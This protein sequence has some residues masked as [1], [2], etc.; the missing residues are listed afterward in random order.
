MPAVL[1]K[2]KRTTSGSSGALRVESAFF[3]SHPDAAG[4]FR[5]QAIA[6]GQFLVS[7]AATAADEDESGDPALASF[8]SFL[9]ARLAA[10]PD[11]V[12]PLDAD[13][14]AEIDDLV[15]DPAPR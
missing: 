4:E 9:E 6:P 8:L 14:L 5:I 7:F 15:G 2:G 3:R 10:E 12:V 11:G 1:Y 13:L